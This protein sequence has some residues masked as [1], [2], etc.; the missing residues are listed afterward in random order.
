[1]PRPDAS[2]RC[3]SWTAGS[4]SMLIDT[5]DVS[6]CELVDGPI[7]EQDAV[8]AH[9]ERHV[10]VA[11]RVLTGAIG[12]EADQIEPK[13]WFA[14]EEHD[15][16]MGRRLAPSFRDREVDGAFRRGAGH[17]RTELL[18]RVAVRAAQV[19]LVGEVEGGGDD[20]IRHDAIML[21]R[22]EPSCHLFRSTLL[23]RIGRTIDGPPPFVNARS[24]LS[25]DGEPLFG[26]R[27]RAPRA[28]S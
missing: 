19:A 14:A 28:G 17:A 4:P 27:A 10:E 16:Q 8:R 26:V 15:L 5:K 6:A 2:G 9:L 1:M 18:A 24:A 25:T 13:E 21:N 11:S 12:D 22:T 3:A 7:V 23:R 20:A